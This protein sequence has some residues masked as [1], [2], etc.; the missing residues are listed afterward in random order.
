MDDHDALYLVILIFAERLLDLVGM[1]ARAPLFLLDDD[2]EAMAASELDPEA[3]ELAEAGSEQLV[4]GRAGIGERGFPGAGAARRINDNL[5]FAGLEDLLQLFEQRQR[6]LG[7]I[8]GSV[9]LH[10]DMHGAQDAVGHIGR[11]RNK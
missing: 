2:L 8:G 1:D 10:S 3:R 7:K 4:T 11:T 6:K 9:V 5:T